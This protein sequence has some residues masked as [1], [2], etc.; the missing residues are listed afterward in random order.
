MNLKYLLL[1]QVKSNLGAKMINYLIGFFSCF[2]L[3]LLIGQMKRIFIFLKK[4]KIGGPDEKVRTGENVVVVLN[5][6][7][8]GKQTIN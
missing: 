1:S 7:T 2:L 8:S 4:P 6:E 5:S 3:L